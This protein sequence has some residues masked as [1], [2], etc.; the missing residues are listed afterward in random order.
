MSLSLLINA[1]IYCMPQLEV[2]PVE[3][4]ENASTVALQVVRGGEEG[5]Q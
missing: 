3:A 4:G 1:A 2:I 5:H